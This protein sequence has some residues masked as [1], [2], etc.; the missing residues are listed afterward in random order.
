MDK[1]IRVEPRQTEPLSVSQI[2]SQQ[3]SKI[4]QIQADPYIPHPRRPTHNTR[5]RIVFW[6]CVSTYVVKF[7]ISPIKHIGHTVHKGKAHISF[8]I[9]HDALPLIRNIGLLLRIERG[10]IYLLHLIGLR[11]KIWIIA[12]FVRDPIQFHRY[13]V[14]VQHSIK[15]FPVHISTPSPH[16]SPFTS[17]EGGTYKLPKHTPR[18]Q[19]T[20]QVHHRP[21][22]S[23]N[24]RVLRPPKLLIVVRTQP[25]VS[26]GPAPDPEQR[27]SG[28][29]IPILYLEKR[30]YMPLQTRRL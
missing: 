30:H 24:P 5:G 15:L 22:N 11:A 20:R 9:S 10:R 17:E 28:P 18:Q 6:R 27:G 29:I 21:Q 26:Q 3:R 12:N 7:L 1:R 23:P 14:C 25:L 2:I 16:T 13:T 19:P 8:H 4:M